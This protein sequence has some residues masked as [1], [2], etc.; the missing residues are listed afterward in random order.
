MT[1]A[2]TAAAKMAMTA[3]GAVAAIAAVAAIT[4]I[5]A[6]R[7]LCNYA[8]FDKAN[9]WSGHDL[10]GCKKVTIVS[11]QQQHGQFQQLLNATTFSMLSTALGDHHHQAIENTATNTN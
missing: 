11:L 9:V 10:H 8:F 3:T 5:A 2:T 7:Q 6:T 4:A 1:I